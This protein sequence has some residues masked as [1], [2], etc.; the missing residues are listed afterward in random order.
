MQCLDASPS[1]GV[2]YWSDKT[3]TLRGEIS[4]QEIDRKGLFARAAFKLDIDFTAYRLFCATHFRS[5]YPGDANK[6]EQWNDDARLE[7]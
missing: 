3:A 2:F 7:I 5:L 4:Q 6:E 1:R